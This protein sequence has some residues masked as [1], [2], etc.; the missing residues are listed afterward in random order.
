MRVCRSIMIYLRPINFW[1][2]CAK[3]TG[4]SCFSKCTFI[5]FFRKSLFLHVLLALPININFL[6]HLKCK[7]VWLI[8]FYLGFTVTFTSQWYKIGEFQMFVDIHSCIISI[9][10]FSSRCLYSWMF[11]KLFNDILKIINNNKKD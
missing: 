1:N 7:N 6:F 9:C 3:R 5:Y 11:W 2:V 10:C 8:S 4:V